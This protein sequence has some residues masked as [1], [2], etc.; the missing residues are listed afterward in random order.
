[1]VGCGGREIHQSKALCK[2][3]QMALMFSAV[4]AKGAKEEDFP[5]LLPLKEGG[6][7]NA[8]HMLVSLCHSHQFDY[9]MVHS[10]RNSAGY[11][12][13]TIAFVL[14]QLCARKLQ[15]RRISLSSF[16]ERKEVREISLIRD[17]L[18]NSVSNKKLKMLHGCT[19][20]LCIE[21]P[22]LHPIRGKD[23]E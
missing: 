17:F 21:R 15:M 3:F 16:L 4:E 5:H 20:V 13:V 23:K 1:M 9:K 11:L 8:P 10:M 19:R 12:S 18:A 14:L 22:I 2:S 6:E 7:G